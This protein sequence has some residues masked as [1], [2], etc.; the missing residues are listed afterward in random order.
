MKCIHLSGVPSASRTQ[1]IVQPARIHPGNGSE[2]ELRVAESDL[3]R[4]GALQRAM[5]RR[6]V[7]VFEKQTTVPMQPIG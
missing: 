6:L 1:H 7:T 3:V 5:S 4:I 2:K